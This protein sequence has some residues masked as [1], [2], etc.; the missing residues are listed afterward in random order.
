MYDYNCVF[1]HIR[2]INVFF[3]LYRTQGK[4]EKQRKAQLGSNN[5]NY[6]APGFAQ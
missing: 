3:V 2:P 5:Q 1:A 6:K 4:K